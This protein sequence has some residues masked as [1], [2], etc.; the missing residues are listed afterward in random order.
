MRSHG[1]PAPKL[2]STG[3]AR[4]LE[5]SRFLFWVNGVMKAVLKG[6]YCLREITHE[7]TVIYHSSR[8]ASPI[9]LKSQ[10]QWI[11]RSCPEFCPEQALRLQLAQQKAVLWRITDICLDGKGAD[12]HMHMPPLPLLLNFF[13]CF[14]RVQLQHMEVPRLGV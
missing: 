5:I 2:S 11:H 14:F 8:L 13:F 7:A 10:H 4:V 1:I 3:A 9:Q 12:M 6:K